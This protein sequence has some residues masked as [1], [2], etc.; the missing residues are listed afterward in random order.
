MYLGGGGG[1]F[2]GLVIVL[3]RPQIMLRERANL[4]NHPSRFKRQIVAGANNNAICLLKVLLLNNPYGQWPTIPNKGLI[5]R[6]TH[7][8][9]H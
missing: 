3:S 5:P 9:N 7:T 6:Q 1:L 2:Y 4:K 8:P